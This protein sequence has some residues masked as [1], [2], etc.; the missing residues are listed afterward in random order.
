MKFLLTVT[1]ALAIVL[2]HLLAACAV[3]LAAF[4]AY[5]VLWGIPSPLAV[6][7]LKEVNAR[8]SFVVEADSMRL[9]LIRG[10]TLNNVRVF[11]KGRIGPAGMQA[12]SIFV[13]PDLPALIEGR[14][15]VSSVRARKGIMYP[16]MLSSPDTESSDGL[17]MNVD[18]RFSV[19]DFSVGDIYCRDLVCRME[20]FGAM[21][22]ATELKAVLESGGV[23]GEVTGEI[24]YD[25]FGD[26]MRGS[27]RVMSDPRVLVPTLSLWDM[28]SVAQLAERFTFDN[29]VPRCDMDFVRVGG[30]TPAARASG[31][32]SL[33]E[34]RYRGVPILKADG[35]FDGMVS[36]TKQEVEIRPFLVV[37]EEGTVRGGLR[38][39][40][41]DGLAEF[42]ADSTVDPK[43]L[44]K[45]LA[46]VS[47]DL[48]SYV[49]FD[50]DVR[51]KVRGTADLVGVERNSITGEMSGHGARASKFVADEF[52]CELDCRG[53][54]NTIRRL[55]GRVYGGDLI[56]RAEVVLPNSLSSNVTYAVALGLSDA[57]FK[58]FARAMLDSGYEDYSGRMSFYARLTGEVTE[59]P[60]LAIKGKGSFRVKDGR[61]FMLPIFGG[62]TAYMTRIIPGLDLVLRQTEARM[63]FEVLGG[64]V[65]SDR[66]EIEGGVLTIGGRGTCLPR[67]D[68]TELDYHIQV[69]LLRDNLIGKLVRLPTW[70]I[71]KLFEFR[72]KG[73]LDEPRWYLVN[74]SG[75]LLSRIGLKKESPTLRPIDRAGK[76]PEKPKA[77][78]AVP[79]DPWRQLGEQ[80][81]KP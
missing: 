59:Y 77:P 18:M 45:M 63:D 65:K 27:V 38:L 6:R 50:G 11:R 35:R 67:P 48:L 40:P 32:F 71:S 49:S 54:T 19:S 36:D 16:S 8:G 78:I 14:L 74:F 12:E 53:S 44:A 66:I 61:V 58:Q 80:E 23:K 13:T 5:M 64:K 43:A 62:F 76:S 41:A 9:D 52:S 60:M 57:E 51:L 3:C 79:E 47:D 37:R 20:V 73:T 46:L 31:S 29:E 22:R 33:P 28:D 25:L 30:K 10:F 68:R 42:D 15:C 70:I 24:T 21:V 2:A 34:C 69:K 26:V 75:D 72:L 55:R 39:F 56:G 7:L 81:T 17:D 1:R 4:V